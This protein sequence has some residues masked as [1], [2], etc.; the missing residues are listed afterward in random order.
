MTLAAFLLHAWRWDRCFSQIV[1]LT[2]GEQ[3]WLSNHLGHEINIDKDY[4]RANDAVLEVAKIS[5]LLM[6]ANSGKMSQYAGK[7]LADIGI[8]GIDFSLVVVF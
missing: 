3:E 5:R 7:S 2:N 8:E 1:S 6:V 4:Y